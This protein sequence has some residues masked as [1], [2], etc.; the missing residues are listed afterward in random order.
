[1]DVA[2]AC[3]AVTS[4]HW[5]RRARLSP[6]ELQGSGCHGGAPRCLEPS[7]KPLRPRTKRLPWE[8]AEGNSALSPLRENRP[9][10]HSVRKKTTAVSNIAGVIRVT[11][12]QR[13][14]TAS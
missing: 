2:S 1:M 7:A 6:A 3:F 13:E 8:E 12:A 4:Y 5:L 14:Q 10:S 9:D 11:G